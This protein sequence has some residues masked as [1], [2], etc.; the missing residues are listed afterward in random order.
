MLATAE[1][2]SFFAD[3]CCCCISPRLACV[4]TVITELIFLALFTYGSVEFTPVPIF[5]VVLVNVIDL[6]IIGLLICGIV[7]ENR[8]CLWIWMAISLLFVISLI[9]L[10]VLYMSGYH[11][12][13]PEGASNGSRIA[14]PVMAVH[15]AVVEVIYILVVFRYFTALGDR[16]REQQSEAMNMHWD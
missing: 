4:I 5:S 9:I 8:T 12:L 7:V 14:I 13:S 3:S 11:I 6:I 10:I 16:E 1:M 15:K 2:P